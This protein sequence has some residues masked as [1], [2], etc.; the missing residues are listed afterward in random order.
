M[1]DI[2][3]CPSTLAPGYNTY[4]QVALRRL[5]DGKKVSPLMD[6]LYDDDQSSEEVVDNVKRISISGVQEKLS[7]I[8]IKGKISLT[9]AGEQGRYIIKPAPNNK[10]LRFRQFIPANEHLT[11]QIAPFHESNEAVYSL[12]ENSFLDDRL[13]RMYKRSYEQR[14]ARFNLK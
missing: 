6:L 14:I 10:T 4:S 1:T 7:A 9:P 8:V 5:F 12:I 11:M 13:K 2:K 3:N